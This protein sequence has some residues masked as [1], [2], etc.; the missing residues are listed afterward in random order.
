[1]VSRGTDAFARGFAATA[2][3]KIVET[4][5]A[6]GAQYQAL[7]EEDQVVSVL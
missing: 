5:Q 3:E 6:M 2:G 4:V 7:I 1:M